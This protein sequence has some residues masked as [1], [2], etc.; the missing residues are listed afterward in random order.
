MNVILLHGL[1]RSR[2]SMA[3]M[4]LALRR[5]GLTPH[6]LGYPSL[7]RP[8][9]FHAALVRAYID[10]HQLQP[11]SFVTHSLGGLVVRQLLA[12]HGAGLTVERVVMLGPPNQGAEFARKVARIPGAARILGPSFRSIA[13]D[14]LPPA[15]ASAEVGIIAGG[16]GARGY[17]PFISGDNDG[18]VS[19]QETEL[20]GMKE[21]VV[22]RGLHSF[23]MY[24]REV[25]EL[26]LRFLTTGSFARGIGGEQS[27]SRR[28]S[29]G[30][31]G[32]SDD[33]TPQP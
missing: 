5:A 27:Q 19:V 30:S 15:L 13:K 6:N 1:G 7:C 28:S 12:R 24:R 23:L 31:Q 4:A 2:F 18:I 22:V 10:R 25:H 17:T 21:R 9:D 11:L 29:D 26:T 32:P 20:P 3:T 14:D 16:C 33:G 8:I